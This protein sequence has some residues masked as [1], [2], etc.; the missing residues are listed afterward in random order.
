VQSDWH[1]KG[2]DQGYATPKSQEEINAA[3]EARQT[4]QVELSRAQKGIRDL[5]KE[6][7]WKRDEASAAPPDMQARYFLDQK[8]LDTVDDLEGL[9]NGTAESSPEANALNQRITDAIG[10]EQRAH[11]A[12]EAVQAYRNALDPKGIPD[13]PF[14]ATWPAL[15]MKRAIRWAADNGFEAVAWTTGEQQRERYNLA[16]TVGTIGVECAHADGYECLISNGAY[17]QRDCRARHGYAS[18]LYAR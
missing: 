15:V 14:K 16:S 12:H 18:R 10:A 3:D 8:T 1:Q 7:G 13:A 17:R 5:A 4:A 9:V 2:R 6:L 11:L